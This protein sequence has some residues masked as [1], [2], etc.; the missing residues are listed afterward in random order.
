MVE[1]VGRLVANLVHLGEHR[2]RRSYRMLTKIQ[3]MVFAFLEH[4]VFYLVQVKAVNTGLIACKPF[5]PMLGWYRLLTL[6][7]LSGGVESSIEVFAA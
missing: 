1:L 6:S 2:V 7:A 4:F 3:S 5:W